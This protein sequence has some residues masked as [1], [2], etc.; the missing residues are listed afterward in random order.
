MKPVAFDNTMLSLLLNPKCRIPDDPLTKAPLVM[1]IERAQGLLEQLQKERRTVVIPT[2]ASAELLTAIGPDAQQYLNIVSRSRV[3]QLAA[4]DGIAAIELAIMN[5]TVFAKSDKKNKSEA[6][7][8]VKFDR[9]IVAIC[10]VTGCEAIYTDDDGLAKRAR[11]VGINP[12]ASW[13]LKI[14]DSKRQLKLELEP[15]ED[16][17]EAIDSDNPESAVVDQ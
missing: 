2:P 9:Q 3:F 17:P 10:K 6:Y 16:I 7:Q 13:D 12:I 8:K 14:P 15:H 1:A 5:R 11:L 4:F